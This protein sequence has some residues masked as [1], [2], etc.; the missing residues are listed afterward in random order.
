MIGAALD[1]WDERRAARGDPWK[2]ITRP[3]VDAALPFP[4]M[5]SSFDLE[6]LCDRAEAAADDPSFFEP[7]WL[8]PRDVQWSDGWIRFP[9]SIEGKVDANNMVHASVDASDGPDHALI[10]LHHWN[11]RRRSKRLAEFF[12]RQ[13]I[14]VVQMAMPYHMERSRPQSEIVDDILSPNLG[15]TLRSMRQAVLDARTLVQVLLDAGYRRVSVLGMSL[16]S[17]VAGIVAAHDARVHV[18][19]LFLSAG[20]LADMVWAGRATRHIR[21]SFD[22][23]IELEQLRRAWAPLDLNRY[24][25][26]LARPDLSLRFVLGRRDDVV[27]PQLSKV[28]L[29]SIKASG[30][31]PRSLWLGC[32]HYSLSLPPFSLWAGRYMREALREPV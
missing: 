21:R 24:A 7:V 28:L 20:S 23:G 17:W 27:L 10:V 2:K 9:S 1:F 4:D 18:G 15:R 3:V 12:V 6:A 16:G 29:N 19:G 8:P 22:G 30:G 13:G 31:D 32:G 25:D 5:A 26:K 11:A 14:T